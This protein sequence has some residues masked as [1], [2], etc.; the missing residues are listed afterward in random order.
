MNNPKVL[1]L[2]GPTASGKTAL[3]VALAASHDIE[4]VCMDS[5]QVYRGMDIGTA[6]PTLEEQRRLP[7]HMLDVVD[8]KDDYSVA[9]YREQAARVIDD[10]L[11]R[12]RLPV[13]VGGTGLYLRALSLP[14]TLG[15]TPRDDQVREKYTA[16]LE[17]QGKQALH[18][19]LTRY[20]PVT[21]QRLHPNDTRRVIRALEVWELTG[22]PFSQ[23]Q[24]PSYADGPYDL[25]LYA[26]HMPRQQLYHRI[27][28][29]VDD[30][31]KQGLLDEVTALINHGVPQDAQAMQGLGY[32][33]L[34][35]VLKGD[36]P[37]DMAVDTLKRRTRNYAKRQMTWFG[38]DTRIRWLHDPDE[39]L[40][41]VQR[42]LEDK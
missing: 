27:D 11:S 5:M 3:S 22:V 17:S 18:A 2:V 37:L 6:K 14:L 20:D 4:I 39:L 10:M 32:K 36:M 31:L 40:P 30:M 16:L 24:M 7:H 1:G 42:D 41:A 33:E 25:K 29:R 8:P 26:L 23:Q 12:G 19:L 15:G 28:A 9:E 38:K 21:A 13:L 35:P 34:V